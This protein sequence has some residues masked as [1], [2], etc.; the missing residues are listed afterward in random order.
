MLQK[1]VLFFVHLHLSTGVDGMPVDFPV[2]FRLDEVESPVVSECS[3]L[4]VDDHLLGLLG[5]I[6]QQLDVLCSLKVTCIS[7]GTWK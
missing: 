7:T 4:R 1:A 6:L 3:P 5:I 2:I